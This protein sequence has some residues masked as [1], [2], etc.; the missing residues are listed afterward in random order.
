MFD[1]CCFYVQFSQQISEQV[2]SIYCTHLS[3]ILELTVIYLDVTVEKRNLT[4]V[5]SV[6]LHLHVVRVSDLVIHSHVTGHVTV[7]I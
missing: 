5:M 2:L 3:F 6:A 4:S 1:F 7:R